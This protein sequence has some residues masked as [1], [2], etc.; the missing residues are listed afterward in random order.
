MS[1][2]S[3]RQLLNT[4]NFDWEN[5]VVVVPGEKAENIFLHAE[6][7]ALDRQFDLEETSQH[8]VPI[9]TAED[10][11]AMYLL[12]NRPEVE[13]AIF[14]KVSVADLEGMNL[15]GIQGYPYGP[16]H[17]GVNLTFTKKPLEVC[18][19]QGSCHPAMAGCPEIHFY[20]VAADRKDVMDLFTIHMLTG[21]ITL[22]NS[23]STDEETETVVKHRG[24]IK[25]LE[26]LFYGK[27]G[28][29]ETR[30]PPIEGEDSDYK[31]D[32]ER[33][34][35]TDGERRGDHPS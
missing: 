9:F 16:E 18:V 33:R 34:T 3:I 26:K 30:L 2:T 32:D 20:C 8:G 21:Y 17:E 35:K 11:A 19:T 29:E 13:K 10:P 25:L 24:Y 6:S 15:G 23:R 28:V 1:L 4:Y 27:L 14:E 12:C 31:D 7:I 22:K 5:G